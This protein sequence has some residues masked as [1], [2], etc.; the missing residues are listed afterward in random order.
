[1]NKRRLTLIFVLLPFLLGGCIMV[2][3]KVT[4][5]ASDRR[6]EADCLEYLQQP[7]LS[8]PKVVAQLGQP[9]TKTDDGKVYLYLYVWRA[10]TTETHLFNPITIPA[11]LAAGMFGGA[12][13][14]L[15][16]ELNA[17]PIHQSFIEHRDEKVMLLVEFDEMNL[18][19]R[20]DMYEYP[21]RIIPIQ[22]AEE[23]LLDP[24]PD[25]F[26]PLADDKG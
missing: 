2:P 25:Y 4:P 21:E 18:V 13:I 14:P 9:M 23:W 20:S 8:K 12:D 17:L 19:T 15:D 26:V 1:M 6:P 22:I 5:S 11:I 7:D 3:K 10:G 24:L 16:D